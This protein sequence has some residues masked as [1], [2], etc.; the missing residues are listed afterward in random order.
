MHVEQQRR[1]SR[2]RVVQLGVRG[3]QGIR[4]HAARKFA[5]VFGIR[6]DRS[7]T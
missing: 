7:G 1:E 3:R 5:V 4:L 2:E 6:R